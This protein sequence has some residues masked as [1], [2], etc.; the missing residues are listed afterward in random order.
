MRDD[1]SFSNVAIANA[2]YEDEKSRKPAYTLTCAMIEKR[3]KLQP[4]QLRNWRANNL[5]R[6]GKLQR[7]GANCGTIVPAV[8]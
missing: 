5:S 2:I 8:P 1:T 4:G 3:L 6:C 7:R